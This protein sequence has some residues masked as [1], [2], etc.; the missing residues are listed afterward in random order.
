MIVISQFSNGTYAAQ[1]RG[2]DGGKVLYRR[3]CTM[4]YL[5]AAEAVVSKF[6]GDAAKAELI[7]VPTH[8]ISKY[9]PSGDHIRRSVPPAV[10]LFRYTPPAP[11]EPPMSKSSKDTAPNKAAAPSVLALAAR[12][13][14]LENAKA[15]LE[16][17]R[18]IVIGYEEKLAAATLGNRLQM[19]L[20]CL[21]A[22]DI[23]LVKSDARKGV[24]GRGKKN[25]VHV[26]GVSQGNGFEGW[27][28]TEVPWLKKPTAYRYMTAVRGLSLDHSAKEGQVAAALKRL[29]KKGDPVSLASL[30]AAA[31][32]PV[33]PQQL[34]APP[35]QQEF[36]F[37]KTKLGHF[38]EESEGL[39]ALKEQLDGL[40]DL[41]R[42]AVAR[43][44]GL[45][46]Q[47]TG[48]YWTPSDEPDELASVDPDTISLQ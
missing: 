32:E 40:P 3:T 16:K 29:Q 44:Y 24:G 20:A 46:H 35:Q 11:S 34:P 48:T 47:L 19:G 15:A 13:K 26:D 2:S 42:A 9:L 7:P 4:G 37:L 43:V 31:T 33:S 25:S 10:Y 1:I 5:Q 36:D 30:I 14:M 45:L 6:F 22:Y 39:L 41:K 18:D 21:K 12:G 27:L 23:F 28:A 38:R 17:H 8:E